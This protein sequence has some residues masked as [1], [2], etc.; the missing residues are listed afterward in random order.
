MN[1]YISQLLASKEYSEPMKVALSLFG[2]GNRSPLALSQRLKPYGMTISDLHDEAVDAAV[3]FIEL[4]LNDNIIDSEELFLL[5]QFKMYLKIREGDFITSQHEK[6]VSRILKHQLD[7]IY[8]DDNVD[9]NEE[10]KK[11]DLQELFGLSYDQFLKY[12]SISVK[13]ALDGGASLKDLDTFYKGSIP[14]K[15]D[16]K[17]YSETAYIEKDEF[18]SQAARLVVE[19]QFGSK[20]LLQRKLSLGY[21]RAERIMNQLENAGI[22]GPDNGDKAR[23]VLIGSLSDLEEML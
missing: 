4:V 20:S 13:S 8:S 1:T 5:R 10:L 11:V 2:E 7:M 3:G 19:A 23:Q 18:F 21:N 16:K 22:V 14:Q 9:K 15:N 17:T 12:D 6:D